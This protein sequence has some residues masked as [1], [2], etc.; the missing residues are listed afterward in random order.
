MNDPKCYIKFIYTVEVVSHKTGSFVLVDMVCEC[1]GIRERVF[2]TFN[3]E[4]EYRRVLEKGY[5]IRRN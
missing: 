2:E 5:Y 1:K 4:K 3:T